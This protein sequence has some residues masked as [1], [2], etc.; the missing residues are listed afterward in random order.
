MWVG[1]VSQILGE[2]QSV[3]FNAESLPFQGLECGK[4]K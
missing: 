1:F 2:V 3:I 4:R